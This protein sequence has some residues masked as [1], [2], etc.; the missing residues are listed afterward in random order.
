MHLINSAVEHAQLF[1]EQ[2]CHFSTH[3]VVYVE[4]PN[5]AHNIGLFHSIRTEAIIDGIEA[6]AAWV[7]AHNKQDSHGR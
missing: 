1:S 4:L 5:P 3:P 7:L 6:F 2:L